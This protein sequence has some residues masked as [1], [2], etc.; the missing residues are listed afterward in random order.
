MSGFHDRGARRHSRC[1]VEHP[2]GVKAAQR[3]PLG[4]RS[5]SGA[6]N[7]GWARRFRR[8]SQR[9]PQGRDGRAPF[10]LVTFLLARKEKRLAQG[11]ETGP[12]RE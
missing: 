8:A 11:G 5:R 2:D 12:F 4:R 9:S 6:E 10:L 1:Y 7:A 3:V